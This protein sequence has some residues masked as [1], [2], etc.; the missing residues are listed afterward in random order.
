MAMI[1]YG[2]FIGGKSVAGTS[3][4]FGEIVNRARARSRGAWPLRH[5]RN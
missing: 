1:D 5:G 4:R 2:H 3:G